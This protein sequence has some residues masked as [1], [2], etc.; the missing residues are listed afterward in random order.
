M[1]DVDDGSISADFECAICGNWAMRVAIRPA[2]SPGPFD[3]PTSFEGG[4]RNVAIETG[5]YTAWFG[6]PPGLE[7]LVRARDIAGLH[8]RNLEFAPLWCPKCAAVYCKDHWDTWPVFDPDYPSWFEETRGI[9]PNGHERMI[10][11]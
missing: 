10:S 7:D 4:G 8:A 11:D 2:G 5:M 1:R 3:Q 9:C 6:E